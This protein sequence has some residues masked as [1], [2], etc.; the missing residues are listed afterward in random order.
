M[1]NQ[2]WEAALFQDL[3]SAPATMEASKIAD[4]WSCVPGHSMEQ[5]DAVQAYI[6]AE[7]S[8]TPTWISLPE[9]AWT[10]APP[11]VKSW[12]EKNKD[13]YRRPVFRLLRAL[14]GHPDSGTFWEQHC[15]K[16]LRAVGFEPILNWPSCYVHPDLDLLLIVYVDDF[17]LS[18]CAKNLKRGWE[19]IRKHL[20]VEE[21]QPANL[22]LGCTHE[23][24]VVKVGNS[25]VNVVTYNMEDYLASTVDAYC[26]MVKNLTN[27]DVKLIQVPT[28]FLPEDQKWS[29]AGRPM[30][31]DCPTCGCPGSRSKKPTAQSGCKLAMQPKQAADTPDERPEYTDDT[32]ENAAPGPP[33]RVAPTMAPPTD[34][35]PD[36]G[37]TEPTTGKTKSKKKKDPNQTPIDPD[38]YNLLLHRY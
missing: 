17:K 23:R 29:E 7:L 38:D 25:S 2:N 30:E 24:S 21:E 18:G 16:S 20:E 12:Y 32:M 10:Y 31:E 27:E 22:F 8:G 35:K 33:R 26:K 1:I 9:E 37:T 4:M 36:N 19:L 3:G 6:Q 5:A 15:D 28:P 13:K 34:V 11:A 14:Y